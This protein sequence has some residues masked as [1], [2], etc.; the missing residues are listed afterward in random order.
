MS[1]HFN[2]SIFTGL[3]AYKYTS[4]LAN[5]SDRWDEYRARNAQIECIC[6]H[7][8]CMSNTFLKQALSSA[9]GDELMFCVKCICDC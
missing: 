5:I 2:V 3:D 4:S 7:F 1:I 6:I 8:K 9:Q